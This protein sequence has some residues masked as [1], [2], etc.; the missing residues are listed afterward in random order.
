MS[1]IANTLGQA[2]NQ[3]LAWVGP[4]VGLVTFGESLIV[5]GAV[6]PATVI[7]L[8]AGG[9]IATGAVDSVTVIAWAL[10]GA[11]A[12]DAASFALGQ[13]LGAR[14]LR[15]PLLIKYRRLI[16]RTR[17][18][19]RRYGVAAIYL[20]RFAG[21]FRAFVPLM[22]GVNH[23]PS[24][25]FHV[26]NLLSGAL[27]VGAFLAPGF[28]AVRGASLVDGKILIVSASAATLAFALVLL[29]RPS[30]TKIC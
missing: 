13:R 1:D 6:L 12:G 27:W 25:R 26:A 2:V 14:V 16:A 8:L 22:A 21:P 11:V 10:A 24:T 7:L 28:I 30:R 18:L 5:I 15:H 3:N 29:L 4:I 19:T 17:L 20:G 9:L 23:M